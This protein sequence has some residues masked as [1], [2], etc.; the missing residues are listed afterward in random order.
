MRD[1]FEVI[2]RRNAEIKEL[3]AE[4]EKRGVKYHVIENTT[5]LLRMFGVKVYNSEKE[6]TDG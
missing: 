2:Q 4:V 3:Q 1:L 5:Q 6:E